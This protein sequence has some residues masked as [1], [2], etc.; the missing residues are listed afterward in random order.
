MDILDSSDKL[1]FLSCIFNCVN[2][3]NT[4]REKLKK[5]DVTF[6]WHRYIHFKCYYREKKKTESGKHNRKRIKLTSSVVVNGLVLNY[7]KQF[8]I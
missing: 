1:Q 8:K 7:T 2:W 4:L 6:G 3:K 5:R